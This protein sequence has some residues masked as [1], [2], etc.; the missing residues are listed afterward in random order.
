MDYNSQMQTKGSKKSVD[1]MATSKSSTPVEIEQVDANPIAMQ[2]EYL[3]NAL[4][5]N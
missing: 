1:T 2:E 4:R 5:V 3:E